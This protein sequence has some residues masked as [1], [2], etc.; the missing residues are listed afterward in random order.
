MNSQEKP[1]SYPGGPKISDSPIET[2][3]ESKS[4]QNNSAGM[5]PSIVNMISING[6]IMAK[7]LDNQAGFC[8]QINLIKISFILDKMLN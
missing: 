7:Y 8:T 6:I 4:I 1:P 2:S 3:T 5:E